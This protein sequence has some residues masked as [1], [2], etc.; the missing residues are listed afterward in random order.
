MPYR[1]VNNITGYCRN[2]EYKVTEA[3]YAT[4]KGYDGVYR[5]ALAATTICPLVPEKCPHFETMTQHYA[6]LTPQTT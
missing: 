5:T 3:R 6:D 4:Q 2:P 1:C